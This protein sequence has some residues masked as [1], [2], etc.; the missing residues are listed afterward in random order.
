MNYSKGGKEVPFKKL[1]ADFIAGVPIKRKPW[2]GYWVYRYGK[3][4]IHTKKGKVVQFLDTEDIIFTLSGIL[5]NDWEKAT[6]ENCPMLAK[7]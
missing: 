5:Q 3:I 1:L 4:D 7:P 6:P 2:G